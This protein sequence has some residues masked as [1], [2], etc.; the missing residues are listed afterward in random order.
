MRDLTDAAAS[1]DGGKVDLG[2]VD[3][4]EDV[5]EDGGRES[6]ADLDQLGVAV[7]RRPDRGEIRVADGAAGLRELADEASQRVALVVAAGLTVADLL[8]RLRLPAG[9]PGG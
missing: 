6:Q 1:R 7:A 9:A 8:Q 5:G 2:V 4:V 3:A